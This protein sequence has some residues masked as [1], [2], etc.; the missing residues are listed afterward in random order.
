VQCMVTVAVPL[1]SSTADNPHAL[2]YFS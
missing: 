2:I 1:Q